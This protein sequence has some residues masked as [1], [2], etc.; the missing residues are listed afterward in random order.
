[1]Q[2][3]IRDVASSL[4]RPAK[5]LKGSQKVD[6]KAGET[7]TVS[8]ELSTAEL[9]FY[10]PVKKPQRVAELGEFEVLI[11]GSSRDIRTRACFSLKN[12]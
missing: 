6:I 10:D 5:V 8:F 11:G 3:Y 7:K 12:S 1:M 2:L 9:S 4:M